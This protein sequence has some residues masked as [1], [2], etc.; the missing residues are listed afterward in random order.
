M[1]SLVSRMSGV[2]N[3]TKSFSKDGQIITRATIAKKAPRY[4]KLNNVL[5]SIEKIRMIA[6]CCKTTSL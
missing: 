3:T 4:P 6:N 5:T 1:E 2:V